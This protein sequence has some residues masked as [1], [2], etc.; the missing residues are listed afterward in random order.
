MQSPTRHE[1]KKPLGDE[2]TPLGCRYVVRL[3]GMLRGQ[4]RMIDARECFRDAARL[5]FEVLRDDFASNLWRSKRQPEIRPGRTAK[6]VPHGAGNDQRLRAQSLDLRASGVERQGLRGERDLFPL[7]EYP[8]EPARRREAL[9]RIAHTPRAIL[10]HIEIHAEGTD[11][12]EERQALKVLLV[13]HRVGL[14]LEKTPRDKKNDER[15]PPACVIAHH[16]KRVRRSLCSQCVESFYPDFTERSSN[17]LFRVTGKPG[18]KPGARCCGNHN[19]CP[20]RR[21]PKSA[22]AK[23][24]L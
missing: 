10:G 17:A 4:E 15:V 20:E 5:S 24:K 2:L 23:E 9:G 1:C 6:H 13:H 18:K 11:L 21:E 19:G 8:H 22:E 3:E 14:H 12:C 7:R 16:K